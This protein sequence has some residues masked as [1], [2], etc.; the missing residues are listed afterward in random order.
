[1]SADGKTIV[2]TCSGWYMYLGQHH[3]QVWQYQSVGFRWPEGERMKTL[4]DPSQY[5]DYQ[6]VTDVS[7]DG[8]T[9]VGKWFS[10][11][12]YPQVENGFWWSLGPFGPWGG[13][14]QSLD[15]ELTF[16]TI[17]TAVSA[18]GTTAVGMCSSTI[19]ESIVEAMRWLISL[20]SPEGEGLGLGFLPGG[21]S[22]I[23]CG[24][25]GDGT[26]VVGFSISADGNQA[27]RWT[28]SEGMIGLGVLPGGGPHS[29]AYDVSADG[30]LV[31]GS[32]DAEPDRSGAFIWTHDRGMRT[33]DD[34]LMEKGV[35]VHARG[36]T[37]LWPARTSLDGR[38]LIGEGVHNGEHEAFLIDLALRLP[39]KDDAEHESSAF[40]FD[41]PAEVH[42]LHHVVKARIA[43]PQTLES[44]IAIALSIQ[45]AP[46]LG[47]ENDGFTKCES[48]F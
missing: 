33:L 46:E 16:D 14:F 20:D 4:T 30:N 3:E 24:V 23:A 40:G 21:S 19:G 11:W 39:R 43:F 37:A 1:M 29:V 17:P 5:L 8:K 47:D 9:I 34:I 2:G 6:M 45:V 42:D 18:D 35:N 31:I 44:G 25:S 26:V 36:W 27:F 28:K 32:S 7:A 13:S 12:N 38:F 41:R 48:F 10:H 22:S 15:L